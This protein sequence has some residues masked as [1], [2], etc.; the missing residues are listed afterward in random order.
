M[1]KKALG[2]GLKALIGE[3]EEFA[4]YETLAS[5]QIM[6]DEIEPNPRQPRENFDKQK[7]ADL[8]ASVRANGVI[9][10]I[11]VR[12]AG[13]KYQIVAGERRWRAAQIAGMATIPVIIRDTTD[14]EM[15]KLALIENLQREDLNPIEEATAYQSLI[16]E[17]SLTQDSLA[18]HIGKDRS[19]IANTLRLLNLPKQIQDY[20]SRGTISM[21]H[22]RALL[23]VPDAQIQQEI[24]QRIIE[25][26]LSVRQ[27]EKL[28]KTRTRPRKR[29]PIVTDP[30]LR[31]VEEK[32]QRS[33]GTKVRIRRSGKRGKIEIEF[34]STDEL[35][36]LLRRLMNP[37]E[38]F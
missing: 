3:P 17:F 5:D 18:Q 12:K 37:E 33:L 4:R 23:S 13:A 32:L 24:S 35:E 31:F 29:S 11:I 19:T 25:E 8:V 21:G 27:V 14:E 26:D 15:L 28:V 1:E 16:Q 6:L 7:L 34:Y 2:K 30:D 10:P 22:A 20:V 38:N 9:Q 36:N